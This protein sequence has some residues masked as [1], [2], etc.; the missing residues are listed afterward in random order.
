MN[1]KDFS[2]TVGSIPEFHLAGAGFKV[3]KM[4]SD[5][6]GRRQ[7]WGFMSHSTARELPVSIPWFLVQNFYQPVHFHSTL[8]RLIDVLLRQ[9]V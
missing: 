3:A 4:A 9:C 7:S 6:T 2:G 5:R 8:Q 1:A